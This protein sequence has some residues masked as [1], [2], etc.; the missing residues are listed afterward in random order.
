M[1]GPSFSPSIA[2]IP[3][4]TSSHSRCQRL[5]CAARV[6]HARAVLRA[7]RVL[8]GQR[9]RARR[10]RRRRQL[11]VPSSLPV[12]RWRGALVAPTST[13]TRIAPASWPPIA[14][15]R[16]PK[17]H[18]QRAAERLA[19]A[20]REALAGRDAAARPGSAASPGRS[21]RRART[22][23]RRRAAG[24]PCD[25]RRALLE[26]ELG[27]RD[28]VAVGVDRRVPELGGDQLLEVLGEHV[29][30]HLRLGVDA[31][32][33]HPQRLGEEALEQAVVADHL[34]REAPPVGGQAHA[35][36]GH[37][38]DQPQLVELLEHRRDRAGRDAQALG[39]RVG[40][41]RLVAAGLEREDRLG[42]VLDGRRAQQILGGHGKRLWHAKISI[43]GY[44]K[45]QRGPVPTPRTPASRSP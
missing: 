45:T 42:V 27:A 23:P 21:P 15:S 4:P 1:L 31:I 32:P 19:L 3:G 39:Q 20:H 34:E 12:G 25:A 13:S 18:E 41:D 44:L 29:L 8:V 14:C 26:L 10:G 7:R 37:V 6:M 38:R 33:G 5:R 16:S 17:T 35:A 22:A 36:V 9:R 30:E 11:G 40:R 28:R 43:K 2:R 24:S